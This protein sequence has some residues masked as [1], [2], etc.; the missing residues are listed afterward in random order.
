MFDCSEQG[1]RCRR[2]SRPHQRSKASS[3]LQP[4]ADTRGPTP[5]PPTHRIILQWAPMGLPTETVVF[6][7][8]RVAVMRPDEIRLIGTLTD[9]RTRTDLRDYLE[10]LQ[11]QIVTNGF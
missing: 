5:A 3:L 4:T 11:R 7:S 1:A 2:F 10:R 8:L 6:E 9:E